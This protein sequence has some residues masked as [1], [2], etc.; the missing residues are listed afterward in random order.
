MN[1]RI[2]ANTNQVAVNKT[3]I[4]ALK[5]K[6]SSNSFEYTGTN[7]SD[8]AVYNFCITCKNKITRGKVNGSFY[9]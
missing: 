5:T 4:A 9:L 6:L 8:V 3:D 7:L 1:A 2:T